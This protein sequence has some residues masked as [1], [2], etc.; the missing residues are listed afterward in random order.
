MADAAEHIAVVEFKGAMKFDG[1]F[2]QVDERWVLVRKGDDSSGW[3]LAGVEAAACPWR[4][5]RS[6]KAACRWHN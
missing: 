2:E 4:F 5:F 6:H 3:L 1:E